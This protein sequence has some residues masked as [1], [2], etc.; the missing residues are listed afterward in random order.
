M[1][2]IFGHFNFLIV[3]GKEYE[4]KSNTL[5][6]GF[7]VKNLNLLLCAI[8][9]VFNISVRK[10]KRYGKRYSDYVCTK[11]YVLELPRERKI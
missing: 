7:R 9:V 11:L 3:E 10:Y 6:A 5:N 1:R 2:I 8:L 4:F